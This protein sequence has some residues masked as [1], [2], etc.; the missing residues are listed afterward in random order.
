MP[1]RVE[2]CVEGLAAA[3]AAEAGGADRVEL[4][5]A[6]NLD[7]LTPDFGVAGEVCSRLRIP[8]HVLIRPRAGGFIY[9]DGEVEGMALAVGR[10][11]RLGASGVVIGLNRADDTVDRAGVAR[12]VAAS[13]PMSVTYHKAFDALRDPE[14]GLDTLASLGVD[15][16]LTSGHAPTVRQ[17]LDVLRRLVG[18]TPVVVLAGGRV[19]VA[20]VPAILAAGVVEI[21]I[22]SAAMKEGV[23]DA[24]TVRRFVD[25]V[26]SYGADANVKKPVP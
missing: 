5:Q 2:V 7:G 6:L 10:A 19:R 18:R 26:R 13:R 8:V 22:G 25:A 23:T 4:C 3:L 16:V 1:V 12:L 21:H 17:G 14:E 20:D 9:D 24:A 15:R 11:C